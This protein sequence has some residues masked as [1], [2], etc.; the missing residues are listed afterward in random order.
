MRN[1]IECF[2]GFLGF[3]FWRE[4][5][6]N[7]SKHRLQTLFQLLPADVTT[8]TVRKMYVGFL[9]F[10][11]LLFVFFFSVSRQY[12]KIIINQQNLH[13][14]LAETAQRTCIV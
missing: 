13:S 3:F 14:K 4:S 6:C 7:G 10:F 2:L 11:L 8:M 5:P 1:I 12:L 9:G